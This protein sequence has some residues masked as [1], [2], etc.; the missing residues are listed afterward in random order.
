M[1][2]GGASGKRLGADALSRSAVLSLSHPVQGGHIKQWEDVEDLWRFAY[3]QDAMHTDPSEHAVMLVDAPDTTKATRERMAQLFFDTFDV[4]SLHIISQPVPAIYASGRLTG[5]VVESG[6]G[7]SYAAAVYEGF[8]ISTAHAPRTCG[9][10]V[11]D[12]LAALLASDGHISSTAGEWNALQTMKAKVCHVAFDLSGT[13]CSDEGTPAP[14]TAGAGASGSDEIKYELPDG[15]T[16]VIGDEAWR[17]TEV[18]WQSH[19][20][21]PRSGGS[22]I[23][24]QG[25]V[26]RAVSAL[27]TRLAEDMYRNVVLSGGNTLFPGFEDRLKQEILRL[28]PA[29]F[30]VNVT[31]QTSRAMNAWRGAAIMAEWSGMS[32]KWVTRYEYEEE[33]PRALHAKCIT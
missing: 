28:L 14:T 24:L 22:G 30:N 8:R 15:T 4:P 23:G 33:G 18:L 16:L 21:T 9:E 19:D 2:E 12:S 1:D 27:D 29:S 32:S 11:S 17:A 20:G 10:A 3:E 5:L 13:R 6:H 25:A 26:V 31:A 7:V